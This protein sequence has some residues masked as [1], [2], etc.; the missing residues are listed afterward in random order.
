MKSKDKERLLREA[1]LDQ[2]AF[3]DI[4]PTLDTRTRGW[5]G[6]RFPEY[7]QNYMRRNY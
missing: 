1:G 6:N 3:D 7:Y 2:A 5:L 4:Y